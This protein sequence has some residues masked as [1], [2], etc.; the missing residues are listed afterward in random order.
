MPNLLQL[1]FILLFYA[2]SSDRLNPKF[3]YLKLRNFFTLLIAEEKKQEEDAIRQQEQERQKKIEEL[4][5]KLPEEPPVESKDEIS[6]IQFRPPGGGAA[7]K[8]K[9]YA[10]ERLEVLLLFV[11]SKGLFAN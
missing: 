1:Y 9:F 5:K 3:V 10:K 7:F 4:Q 6:T 11:E 8:R 2:L